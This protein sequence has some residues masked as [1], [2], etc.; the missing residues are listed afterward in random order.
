MT[1]DT[2]AQ[3]RRRPY[4]ARVSA[5]ERHAQ[6]L[7]AALAVIVRDG[8]DKVSI[9]AIARQAGVTR[10]VVY[11][12]F[13]NLGALLSVLLDRQQ[14]RA[15]EQLGPLLA[16]GFDEGGESIDQLPA[17][18]RAVAEAIKG[19][20]ATWR[21]ILLEPRGMPQVVRARISGDRQLVREILASMIEAAFSG[22]DVEP[23]VEVLAHALV[24]VL[25]H[26]ARILL[27]EPDLF[28]VDRL[29]R[30]VKVVL[31]AIRT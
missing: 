24:A 10:P 16:T 27:E 14:A 9:D 20:P 3:R 29:V 18:I 15:M 28:D 13:E 8:Y 22:G 21:P 2:K 12:V 4:A 30:S 19:D 25:E 17:V 31:D 1:A 5:A 23:D 11:G 7:D 26:F 6:L